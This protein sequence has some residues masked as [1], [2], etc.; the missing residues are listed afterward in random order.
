MRFGTSD[1]LLDARVD[2]KVIFWIVDWLRA[3]GLTVLIELAVTMPLLRRVEPRAGRRFAV[4][5]MA[6]LM[7]HPLVWFLFPG[8]SVPNLTR[9]VISEVWAVVGETF[10]YAVIWPGLRVHRAALVSLA[11]NGAS[12]AVGLWLLPR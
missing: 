6:N 10:A 2:G 12:F 7:T 4:V 5:V 11:A 1:A 3:F 9:T 8:L